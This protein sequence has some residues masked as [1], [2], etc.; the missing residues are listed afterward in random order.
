MPEIVIEKF[1]NGKAVDVGQ[2]IDGADGWIAWEVQLENSVR[3]DLL[4]T[5]IERD[6]KAGYLRVV[7]C[8]QSR[9]DMAKVDAVIAAMS[10]V[11]SSLG[12]QNIKEKVQS[13]LLADF[14]D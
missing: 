10:K 14:L 11:E 9:K 3:D 5:L 13:K 1:L 6:L 8:V 7:I 12:L 2:K 4:S